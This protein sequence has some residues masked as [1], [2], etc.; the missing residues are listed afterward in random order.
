M[1]SGQRH[2]HVHRDAETL[3]E[4]QV[5]SA[6]P[7]DADVETLLVDLDSAEPAMVLARMRWPSRLHTFELR[8]AHCRHEKFCPMTGA[9]AYCRGCWIRLQLIQHIMELI[10]Q[11]HNF[12]FKLCAPAKEPA[13]PLRTKV[14]LL[15]Q[16]ERQE[17][18]LRIGL[19]CGFK[20]GVSSVS[21]Q[22]GLTFGPGKAPL[23]H[24]NPLHKLLYDLDNAFVRSLR[25]WRLGKRFEM[26]PWLLT[27]RL[28]QGK[29]NRVFGLTAQD[30][31]LFLDLLDM[32]RGKSIE[33]AGSNIIHELDDQRCTETHLRNLSMARNCLVAGAGI[34]SHKLFKAMTDR[35]FCSKWKTS[36]CCAL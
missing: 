10:L 9:Q 30:S 5:V 29:G 18:V 28:L 33:A 17:R 7:V 6:E 26:V 20:E 32:L 22:L 21:Q 35:A 36:L 1:A 24:A 13:P 12:F 27:V 16:E 31:G 23:V 25:K 3:R 34:L 4:Q 2:S 11:L 19:L 15:D 8:R 14:R